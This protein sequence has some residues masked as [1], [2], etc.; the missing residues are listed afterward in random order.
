[1][2]IVIVMVVV[3]MEM[4]YGDSDSDGVVG[5]RMVYGDGGSG[6]GENIWRW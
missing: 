4:T 3:G 1:M 5:M 6:D 2:E